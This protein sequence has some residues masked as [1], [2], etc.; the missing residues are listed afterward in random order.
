MLTI[1]AAVAENGVIGD[2]NRL[3]WHISEDLRFFKKPPKDIPS[4]WDEKRFSRLEDHFQIA[5]TLSFPEPISL[6][7]KE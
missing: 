4:L 1:I 5:K 7:W 2:R 6:P 3:I